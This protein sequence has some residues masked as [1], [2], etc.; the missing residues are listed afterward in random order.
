MSPSYF[1]IDGKL[2]YQDERGEVVNIVDASA[3]QK[4]AKILEDGVRLEYGRGFY[5][6]NYRKRGE[7]WDTPRDAIAAA[8][9]SK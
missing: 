1:V 8:M 4:I 5:L 6:K 2:F 9:R 3:C 7:Y